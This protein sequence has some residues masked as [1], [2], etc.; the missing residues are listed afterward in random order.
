MHTPTAGRCSC[1]KS[2]CPAPGK[3]PRIAWERLA[4]SPATRAEVEGWWRRWPQANLAVVTGTVSGLVVLDVDPRHGGDETVAALE[5]EHG[6]MPRTVKSLTGGGGQHFYFRHP[7]R[8]IVSRVIAPGLELKAEGGMVISPPSVHTTGRHY[9]WERGR[10]PSD[11]ALA[12][13]P[14]WLLLDVLDLVGGAHRAEG[15]IPTRTEGERRAFAALWAGVGIRLRRGDH[16]YLCPFHEDHHPSLDIDAEGCRF[17]CFGCARGGGVAR[18]R[19]LADVAAESVGAGWDAAGLLAPAG[20]PATLN[21]EHNIR[22]VG[23]SRYQDELL[24]LTGGRRHWAGARVRTV[25]HL[26]PEPDNPTD[27]NAVAVTID[28]RHVGYLSRGDALSFRD[29]ITEAIR[30]HGRA[31]C[32]AT[33]VGGWE[34]GHGDVGFFG[35]HLRL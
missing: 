16:Y 14:E 20:E 28:G 25:A 22:V 26:V 31:S 15:E 19:R 32:V 12:D 1:G 24:A 8:R 18:L 10:V 17:Y 27:P 7:G 11:V 13:L 2:V 30:Q 4:R 6:S 3:H 9:V 5:A 23:G 33:I 29:L 34:R 35:V 21:G